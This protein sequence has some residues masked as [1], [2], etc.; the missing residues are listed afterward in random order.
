MNISIP[1]NYLKYITKSKILNFNKCENYFKL[2]LIQ[3]QDGNKRK[4]PIL[5]NLENDRVK[6]LARSLYG[7]LEILP[8]FND[9][10]EAFRETQIK[11]DAK[12]SI[13]HPVLIS[14]DLIAS[15]DLLIVLEDGSLEIVEIVTS[16]NAKKDIEVFLS[17]YLLVSKELDLPV[18]KLTV[19]KIN[20]NYILEESFDIQNF[21]KFVDYTNKVENSTALVQNTIESIRKIR[22]GVQDENSIIHNICSNIKGCSFQSACFPDIKDGDLTTLRESSNIINQLY[23]ANIFKLSDIPIENYSEDLTKKQIIQIQSNKEELEKYNINNLQSF[24]DRIKFPVYYLDFE[25]INP[26]IPFYNKTKAFQHVPFLYSL[27]IWK[28]IESEEPEHHDFIQSNPNDPRPSILKSLSELIQGEGTILCFNDFFEKR[29][30]QES[31]HFLPEYSDWLESIRGNF[32]D[33][34]IPFKSLDYYSF[35]QKGSASLKDILPALTGAS[36]EHLDIQNG[37]SANLIYLKWIQSFS[38]NNIPNGKVLEQLRE[39]CKMDTWALYLIHKKLLE[40]CK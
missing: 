10:L 20:S 7:K 29:C 8:K 25:T 24:L 40:I 14:K 11:I 21:F 38:A 2:N 23:D 12:I 30:I 34:A 18:K 19:I 27:H 3:S 22:D 6:E 35:K 33:A 16:V 28:D 32:L 26:Q 17:F 36:H 4:S 37:H 5:Y 9:V 39:Y 1:P 31:V 13:S 15:P